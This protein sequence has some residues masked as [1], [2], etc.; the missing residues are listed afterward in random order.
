MELKKA[1]YNM[2]GKIVEMSIR[3]FRTD[4][5]VGGVEGDCPPDYDSL[6]WHRQM[7]E[8]GHLYQAEVNEEIVGGALLFE[9]EKNLSLYVGRIFIDSFHHRKGYGLLLMQCIENNFP[10]IRE[11]NLDTPEWNVRT[12]A[13]YQKLGYSKV[14]VEDGFTFYK[15]ER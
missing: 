2:I 8:E 7:A 10:D 6:A 9:D 14:K 13:F 11:F 3:A 1:E 12:N 5:A 15:K 4:T